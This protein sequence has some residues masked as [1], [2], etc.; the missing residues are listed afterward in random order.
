MARYSDLSIHV[1]EHPD[2]RPAIELALH[3][4]YPGA[5]VS[6]SDIGEAWGKSWEVSTDGTRGK[7]RVTIICNNVV[8]LCNRTVGE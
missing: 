2:N 7:R 5:I 3:R 4:H 6:T 1:V 8:N